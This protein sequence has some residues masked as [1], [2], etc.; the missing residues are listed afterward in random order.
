LEVH[1]EVSAEAAAAQAARRRAEA[2]AAAA[3]AAAQQATARAAANAAAAHAAASA[4]AAARCAAAAE[5]LAATPEPEE[6]SPDALRVA[7]RLPD[8]RRAQR[9][10]HASSPAALLF[11]WADATP[12]VLHGGAGGAAYALAAAFPR[13][14]LRRGEVMA[15]RA[16]LA[17]AGLPSG[18]QEVLN[19]EPLPEGEAE[20]G[21]AAAAMSA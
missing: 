9:R 3:A 2:A 14:V 13:R 12:G 1:I 16:T 18:A 7:L 11:A 5:S 17:E 6:G 4:S 19:V 20:Q 8:G 21:D 10:F 15:S